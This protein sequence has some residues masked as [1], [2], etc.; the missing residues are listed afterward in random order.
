MGVGRERS[1][2]VTQPKGRMGPS[3]KEPGAGLAPQRYSRLS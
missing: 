1:Q 3:H 2:A